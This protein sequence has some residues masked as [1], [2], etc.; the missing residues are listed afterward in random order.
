MARRRPGAKPLSEPMMVRLSTHICITWS[1][2]V[3]VMLAKVIQH[4]Y[5]TVY[6]LNF[7]KDTQIYIRILYHSSIITQKITCLHTNYHH[8]CE[9]DS[10]RRQ[11]I[12]QH[13]F[14]LLYSTSHIYVLIYKYVHINAWAI[15]T[16]YISLPTLR[17]CLNQCDYIY[18]SYSR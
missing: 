4:N 10:L 1:Q 9:P 16:R 12:I 11:V 6:V 17:N 18:S 13:L 2:W 3:K 7:S 5:S 8:C 14:S 15:I